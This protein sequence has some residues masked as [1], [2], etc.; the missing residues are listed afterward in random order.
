MP[1]ILYIPNLAILPLRVKVMVKAIEAA[2]DLVGTGS[3]FFPRILSSPG[4]PAVAAGNGVR[5]IC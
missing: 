5:P 3:G 1:Y 2:T 4:R